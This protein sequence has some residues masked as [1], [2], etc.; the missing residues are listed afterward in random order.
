MM[1]DNSPR[2]GKWFRARRLGYGAGLPI[3]WQGWTLL[4]GYVLAALAL[5][6]LMRVP[7]GVAKR[8]AVAG[9]VLLTTGFLVIVRLKT[10]GG[11]KWRW[12]T[13]D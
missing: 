3:A 4:G 10:R 1:D 13:R 7:D 9:F 6:P 12:G 11:W 2:D 8:V 5:G